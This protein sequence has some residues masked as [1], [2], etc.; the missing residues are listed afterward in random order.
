MAVGVLGRHGSDMSLTG[1]P[2]CR[3]RDIVMGSCCKAWGWGGGRCQS[4]YP[5]MTCSDVGVVGKQ[6]AELPMRNPQAVLCPCP[7][8]PCR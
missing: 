2:D 4:T 7:A 3:R 6:D 1:P 8:R 5:T